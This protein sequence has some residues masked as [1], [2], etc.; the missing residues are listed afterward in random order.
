MTAPTPPPQWLPPQQPKKR[1]RWPVFAGVGVALIIVLAIIGS[2]AGGGK[3]KTAEHTSI[4]STIAGTP[5]TA[6]SVEA[7]NPTDT[8]RTAISTWYAGVEPDFTAIITALN[9]ISS[10][11]GTTDVD[12]LTTACGSL[13][14]QVITFEAD[15]ASPD[16]QIRAD[17]AKAMDAYSTSA[18]LCLAGDYTQTATQIDQGNVWIGKAT[19]RVHQLAGN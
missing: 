19:S 17:L 13:K 11:A 12:G 4:P 15:P 16:A 3:K 18:S 8:L 10:A 6:A 1:R 7:S 9:A 2:A 5:T 14:R